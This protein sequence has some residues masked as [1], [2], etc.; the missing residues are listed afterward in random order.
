MQ[1]GA[2]EGLCRRGTSR[3]TD[4]CITVWTGAADPKQRFAEIESGRLVPSVQ[5][6]PRAGSDFEERTSASEKERMQSRT[7]GSAYLTLAL[8]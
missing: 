6:W 3:A 2:V 4:R 1:S 5:R 8:R 7:C